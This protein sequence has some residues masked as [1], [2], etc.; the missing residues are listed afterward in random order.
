M[1]KTVEEGLEV[2]KKE[3]KDL[4]RLEKSLE[5]PI[6]PFPA[7]VR[8]EI[9]LQKIRIEGIKTALGLSNKEVEKI[10]K[11]ILKETQKEV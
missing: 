4:V 1:I 3:V 11:E 2:Y 9:R 5:N 10:K 7:V 8:S 6:V